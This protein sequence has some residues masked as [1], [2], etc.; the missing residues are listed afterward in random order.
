M[1]AGDSRLDGSTLSAPA[2][3]GA[4]SADWLLLLCVWRGRQGSAMIPYKKYKSGL[5][6]SRQCCYCMYCWLLLMNAS[7]IRDKHWLKL[8][9]RMDIS[10][11]ADPPVAI[12]MRL[13]AMILFRSL[14]RTSILVAYTEGGPRWGSVSTSQY[15]PS[16]WLCLNEC[17]SPGSQ[18]SCWA[19]LRFGAMAPR[20]TNRLSV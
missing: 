13:D 14:H 16:K 20:S 19:L 1:P 10:A 18:A 5:L 4:V 3:A 8:E 11:V 7:Q 9:Y 15:Q 6:N 12:R 2:D 17:F